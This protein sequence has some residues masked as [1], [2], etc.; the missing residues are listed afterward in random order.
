MALNIK[1]KEVEELAT[2]LAKLTGESKTEA[3]RKALLERKS[4]L[5]GKRTSSARKILEQEIW[6]QIPAEL[7]GK[8]IAFEDHGDLMG[9]G[10][11][12]Y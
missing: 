4:R 8:G 5:A 7:R 6:S 1:N 12:G 2:E 11:S 9:W 3:I 10:P